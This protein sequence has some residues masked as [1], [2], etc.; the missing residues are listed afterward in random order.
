M[1]SEA[2]RLWSIAR[3]LEAEADLTDPTVLPARPRK[4]ECAAT[5]IRSLGTLRRMGAASRRHRGSGC[6]R[7]TQA[8]L[9]ERRGE[10]RAAEEDVTG[11]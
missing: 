7:S 11:V 5:S 1:T 6:A 8:A 10:G 2:Q 4:L 3:E 9:Q